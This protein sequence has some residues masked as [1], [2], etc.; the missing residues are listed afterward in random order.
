MKI[1]L[2]IFSRAAKA[3]SGVTPK[4]T[5]KVLKTLEKAASY[6]DKNKSRLV[7]ISSI[8]FLLGMIG[9]VIKH[10]YKNRQAFQ[11]AVETAQLNVGDSNGLREIVYYGQDN[12]LLPCS[13]TPDDCVARSFEQ[14]GESLKKGRSLS[15]FCQDLFGGPRFT[16]V[17]EGILKDMGKIRK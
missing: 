7:G 4:P 11:K 12:R 5:P 2:P 15:G 8:I 9:V 1:S 10:D 13:K 16:E 6:V 14:A 3:T 17:C